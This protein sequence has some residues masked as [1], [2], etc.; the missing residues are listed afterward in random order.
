MNTQ[1][2]PSPSIDPSDV[3]TLTGTLRLILDKFLQGV[4]D[5]LP[6]QVIAYDR[7]ANM[8]QVQPLILVVGTDG[9]TLERAPLASL[10]VLSLGCGSFVLSLP[11]APG[12]LGWIKAND[13]DISLFLQDLQNHK[14]NTFRKH[15]FSDAIFIPDSMKA[16]TLNPDDEGAA[17]LQS[18]DGTVR[19]SLQ[20]TKLVLTAPTVEVVTP[21]AKFS[22]DVQIGGGLVVDGA[23]GIL[24]TDPLA[25]IVAGVTPAA[26]S[27]RLH[28]QNVTGSVAGPPIP[29]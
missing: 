7:G 29:T 22:A 21:T 11:I 15:S 5:M 17:V 8:V 10:H 12:D 2:N 23:A 19:V 24:T 25:D 3:G 4:D 18:T 27:L 20:P 1:D 16:W 14:P 6:A 28:T 9:S 26:V 13:R